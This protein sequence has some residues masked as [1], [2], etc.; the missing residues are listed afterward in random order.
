MIDLTQEAPSGSDTEPD[1]DVKYD[2]SA[3]AASMI[4]NTG[5]EAK[6]PPP[7]AEEKKARARAAPLD[8]NDESQDLGAVENVPATGARPATF[9]TF[10]PQSV[11]PDTRITFCDLCQEYGVSFYYMRDDP[12]C[13]FLCKPCYASSVYDDA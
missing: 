6:A 11:F 3:L 8:P 7:V 5:A 2:S 1:D 10:P 9:V 4:P 12:D 13:M